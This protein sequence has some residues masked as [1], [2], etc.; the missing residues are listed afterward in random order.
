VLTVISQ[1]QKLALRESFK[2]KVSVGVSLLTLF[3][4]LACCRSVACDA[5]TEHAGCAEV[6]APGSAAEEDAG[7]PE[8]AHPP[9]GA[10]LW[11]RS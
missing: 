7:Y 9:S 11:T 5:D 4:P 2:G 6:F 10:E 1:N 8:A 3:T